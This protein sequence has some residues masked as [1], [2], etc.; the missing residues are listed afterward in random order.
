MSMK[1]SEIQKILDAMFV[2]D[3]GFADRQVVSCGGSDFAEH[4]LILPAKDSLLLTGVMNE[5]LVPSVKFSGVTAVV[6]VRGKVPDDSIV[7][8]ARQFD[9]PLLTTRCSMFVASGRLYLHGL[10][11]LE[12]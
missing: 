7:S 9:L 4:L 12:A 10:R 1:L 8:T 2:F 6:F 5:Q 11:G 3:D